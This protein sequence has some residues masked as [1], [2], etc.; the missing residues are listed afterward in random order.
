MTSSRLGRAIVFVPRAVLLMLSA[1]AARGQPTC[2][3]TIATFSRYVRMNLLDA[4][5][6]Q[7]W[8]ERATKPGLTE[9]F[10]R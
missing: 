9:K 4:T 3:P 1:A 2:G 5:G 6:D 10:Y 8:I 7:A